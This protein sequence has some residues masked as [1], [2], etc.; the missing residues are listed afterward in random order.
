MARNHRGEAR[1]WLDRQLVE[2]Q[3]LGAERERA[4]EARRPASFTIARQG[5]DQVETDATDRRLGR[6]QRAQSL[7][8]GMGAAEKS[9]RL[10]VE[11]LQAEADAIDAGLGEIGEARRLGA[12][13]ISL[14]CDLEIVSLRPVIA[15]GG[16]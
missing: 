3:M 11:A 15:C 16:D 13:G 14:Q 8:R 5:V 12:V 1:A 10:I 4:F 2:R 6:L 7:V 9:E